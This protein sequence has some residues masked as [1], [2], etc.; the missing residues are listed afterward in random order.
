MLIKCQ[1]CGAPLD[2]DPNEQ[3]VR[4]QFCKATTRVEQPHERPVAPMPSPAFP[5]PPAV[6]VQPKG[7]GGCAVGVLALAIA[8][9]GA[10][11][12]GVV[13]LGTGASTVVGKSSSVMGSPAWNTSAGACLLD[14]NGDGVFDVGGLTGPP[15]TGTT[16]TIVD[17]KTGD[18]IWSGEPSIK[19]ASSTCAGDAWLVVH[20]PDFRIEFHDA[21]KPEVPVKYLARDKLQG[22]SLGKGCVNIETQDR[23]TTGVALPGGTATTCNAPKPRRVTAEWPGVVGLTD[24]G[25]TI[26]VGPRK[27]S[28]KKRKS[29]TKMLT[30]EVSEA[31][32]TLWSKELPYASP[33]FNTAI[34]VGRGMV[35]VWAASPADR[36]R[37][38]LVGLDA[39]TGTQKYEHPQ[40][41]QV[42]NSIEQFA[43]NGRYLIA[44][45]WGKVYAYEPKT[46]EIVWT[47][48]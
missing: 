27:Y 41:G 34:A 38:I 45:Y 12:A 23:T 16:P 11:V 22:I 26:G 24:D 35:M 28:V 36:Q 32:K 1:H 33:T 48:G 31:G 44:M 6:R 20:R 7:K 14:A 18:V 10:S 3:V 29:G 25:T 5:Q 42:T 9:V 47:A 17:G 13:A 30:V 15:G 43:F 37:A 46:G 40:D 39:D 19:G 21:R 4:C 2:V 8:L